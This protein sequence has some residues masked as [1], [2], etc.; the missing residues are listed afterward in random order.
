MSHPPVAE[1][2]AVDQHERR[3]LDSALRELGH[4]PAD[5]AVEIAAL[6]PDSRGSLLPIG[7]LRA[8]KEVTVTRISTGDSFRQ[9]QYV[10]GPWAGEIV[11]ALIHGRLGPRD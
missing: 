2:S 1:Q 11:Q 7:L 5:F 8:R 10:D 4:D 9:E 3:L 6:A